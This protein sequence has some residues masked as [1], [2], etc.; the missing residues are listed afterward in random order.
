[1]LRY[2]IKPKGNSVWHTASPGG[3]GYKA[4]FVRKLVVSVWLWQHWIWFSFLTTELPLDCVFVSCTS[5]CTH[6]R[7]NCEFLFILK[8]GSWIMTVGWLGSWA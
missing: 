8:S 7:W 1:M 6:R 5:H 2:L 4:N 3:G